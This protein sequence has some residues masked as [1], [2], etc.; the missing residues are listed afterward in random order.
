MSYLQ[1]P[2]TQPNVRRVP[3]AAVRS[4]RRGWAAFHL[5]TICC[6]THGNKVKSFDRQR[7]TG[8]FATSVT[9]E[10]SAYLLRLGAEVAGACQFNQLGEVVPRLIAVAGLLR[11][12]PRAVQAAITVRLAQLRRLVFLQRLGRAL[13]LHQQVAEQLARRQ[14]APR[15]DDVLVAPVLDVG[16]LAHEA[17]RLV[18]SLLR[19]RDPGERREPHHL[20]LVRPVLVFCRLKLVA[21]RRD[22]LGVLLRGGGI[23]APRRAERAR[24]M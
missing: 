12:L 3:L 19:E 14:Q 15:R 17:E 2:T 5:P 20:D 9:R 16:R 21:Q 23:A 4:R 6:C 1:S 7:R 24:E 11:R 8:A 13:Q 22:P 10:I 18:R